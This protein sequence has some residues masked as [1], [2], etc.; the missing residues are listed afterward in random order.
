MVNT[1][2]LTH[3]LCLYFKNTCSK[4]RTLISRSNKLHFVRRLSAPI[5]Q[6]LL[7]VHKLTFTLQLNGQK[8]QIM[9]KT[10]SLILSYE[11]FI[12]SSQASPTYSSTKCFLFQLPVSSRFFKLIQQLLTYSPL[13]PIPYIF[14]LIMCCR[15]HFLSKMWSIQLALLF[16]VPT[17]FLSSMTIRNIFIFHKIRQTDPPLPSPSTTYENFHSTYDLLFEVSKFRHHTKLCSKCS[18]SPLSSSNFILVYP[19]FW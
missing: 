19:I 17:I 3:S 4:G 2:C 7:H 5:R 13:P 9:K 6:E 16:I 12:A 15:R 11:G 10:Q 18:I 1:D 8:R 14:P